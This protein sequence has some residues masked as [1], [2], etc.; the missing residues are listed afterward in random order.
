MNSELHGEPKRQLTLPR[1]GGPGIVVSLLPDVRHHDALIADYWAT[2]P[3]FLFLKNVTPNAKVLDFGASHGGMS[4]WPGWQQPVREDISLYAIDI[5]RG[6]HFDKYTD[7]DIVDVTKARTRLE[8]ASFDA[9]VC[10]MTLE[11]ISNARGALAEIARLM[12]PGGSLYIEYSGEH[13][14]RVPRQKDLE[15][16]SLAGD[17]INF[18]EDED[19]A[20]LFNSAFLDSELH[21]TGYTPATHGAVFNDR[22]VSELL[23]HGI[24]TGDTETTSYGL[25]LA[26]RCISY[27]IA[28]RLF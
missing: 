10:A 9:V 8:P 15:A 7:F 3:R 5:E 17:P 16:L 23:S 24:Q 4:F 18:Y 14:V 19:H 21:A 28:D 27:T 11:Y 2:H 20:H 1:P 25:R 26:Y 22:L 12:R 13:A 6:F